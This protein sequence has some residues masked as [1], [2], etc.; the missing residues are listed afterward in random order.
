[1]RGKITVAAITIYLSALQCIPVRAVRDNQGAIGVG[2]AGG[3]EFSRPVAKHEIA[4]IEELK[5][6]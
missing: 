3:W 5:T 4:R 2:A 1:L 6:A